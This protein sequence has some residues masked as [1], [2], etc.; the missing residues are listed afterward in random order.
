MQVSEQV[1]REAIGFELADLL[2]RQQSIVSCNES[3]NLLD[4]NTDEKFRHMAE[5]DGKNLRMLE[6]VIG[7]YGIRVEARDAAVQLADVATKIVKNSTTIPLEKLEAYSLLKQNQMMC[8]HLVHKV[9]QQADTDIKFALTPFEG[10][11]ATFSK[12]VS[13][14]SQDLE[15]AGVQWIS[16]KE[17]ESGLLGRA[18]DAVAAFAGAIMSKVAKPADEMS[19]LPVL[20]MDHR[21]VDMLFEE[22]RKA[23][24]AQQEADLF[25]QLKADLTAHSL[26]EEKVVYQTF[27]NIKEMQPKLA[28]AQQEHEDLRTLLDEITDVMEKR[29]EFLDKIDDL[30]QLVKHHVNEEETEIFRLIKKNSSEEV[31]IRLSQD[32]MQ[33]KQRIQENIGTDDV[34]SDSSLTAN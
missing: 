5:E 31:L 7:S 8:G 30:Q 18:K 4:K 28:D 1:M 29:E 34:I 9:I 32:F 12:Q 17:P 20:T 10:I 22:I 24:D 26:A 19:I 6:T 13:E 16:G 3:L 14:L 2:Y 15:Q 27:K 25:H 33:A 21:K 11:Y 23:K